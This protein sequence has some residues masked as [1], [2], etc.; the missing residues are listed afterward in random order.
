[1]KKMLRKVAI[2]L[3]ILIT[4]FFIFIL[5][6]GKYKVPEFQ[7]RQ[8]TKFWHL[9]TG[10]RIGYTLIPARGVKEPYP[11]I[12]LQGGPGGPI[13]N[14][15]IDLLSQLAEDGYDVFLYDQIGCGSSARLEKIAE[16][17][18]DRHRRD[19]EE[20]IKIIG[21]PEV[22]L[23][24]Q[25]W[26]CILAAQY[27]AYNG[28]KV[29]KVV[30]SSPGP[31]MP[32]NNDLK[33]IKTPDS[34]NLITPAY[35][36]RQGKAKIY[37][38]RARVVEFCA[39]A[40]NWKLATDKEMDAFAT[41]LNHEMGKS[42]V[43]DTSYLSAVSQPESGS[44]YYSMIKTAQHFNEVADIRQKLANSNIPALVMRGQCDGIKW[45]FAKEYLQ[46]FKN[47]RLAIVY[48][49]GHSIGIE[50][51]KVYLQEIRKFLSE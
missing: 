24:G 33:T 28:D 32:I 8:G 43:C 29:H 47:H 13:Y 20:I 15:N 49:A 31:L 25:S 40:F 34:L 38:I 27:I 3:I 21:A 19:L 17:T 37:N 36:N 2:L 23:I 11:V 35:S 26:G 51:P 7:L 45:G 10:S 9:L 22:I 39:M 16:Y 6:P 14:R 48:G 50:Q 12:F 44:G 41:I 1:M 30:F 46:L 5:I 18:V 42:T 4:S